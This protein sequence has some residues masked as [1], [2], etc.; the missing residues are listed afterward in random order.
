M[1]KADDILVFFCVSALTY[2]RGRSA[3]CLTK[4]ETHIHPA[5]SLPARGE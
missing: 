3:A 5:P 1:K 4:A 2:N